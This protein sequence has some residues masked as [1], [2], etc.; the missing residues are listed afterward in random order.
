MA[1]SSD[2]LQGSRIEAQSLEKQTQ[3]YDPTKDFSMR[4]VM[5]KDELPNGRKVHLIGYTTESIGAKVPLD[6]LEAHNRSK[7]KES[8]GH[9]EQVYFTTESGSM[10]RARDTR[11]GSWEIEGASNGFRSTI[12]EPCSIKVGERFVSPHL[13]NGEPEINTSRIRSITLVEPNAGLP[14]LPGSEVISVAEQFKQTI[15]QQGS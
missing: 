14:V 7:K 11:N 1:G 6:A 4:R 10:Y 8:W 2:I 13:I 12:A 5:V 9:F 15:R 3:E